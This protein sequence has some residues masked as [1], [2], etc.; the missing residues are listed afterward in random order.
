MST[1][2]GKRTSQMLLLASLGVTRYVPDFHKASPISR[3]CISVILIG[4]CFRR[5]VQVRKPVT[6]MNVHYR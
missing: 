4:I 6:T 2:E 3:G 5:H 1:T